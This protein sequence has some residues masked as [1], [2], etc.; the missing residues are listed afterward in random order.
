MPATIKKEVGE[1]LKS[2]ERALFGSKK[3]SKKWWFYLN[4][5]LH[6][7]NL[8]YIF[9]HANVTP[10]LVDNFKKT[11]QEIGLGNITWIIL[12]LVHTI[13]EMAK[14]NQRSTSEIEEIKAYD[15]FQRDIPYRLPEPEKSDEVTSY[16]RFNRV[17]DLKEPDRVPITPLMDYFYAANNNLSAYDFV[18][19]P[20]KYVFAAVR[21]TYQRFNGELDMVHVPMGRLYTFYNWLPL[22]TSGFYGD[23]HYP[24]KSP[25]SLQFLEKG[26]IDIEDFEKIKKL[27][28][29]SIWKPVNI[30][31]MRETVV[32]LVNIG[33]YID[34]WEKKEHV[35]IYA[36]SG[37]VT[38]LEG[39][40]YLMGIKKWL[41]AI[42]K[43]KEEMK[44]MCDF[45]LE[46]IMANNYMM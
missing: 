22:A 25:S 31:K 44:Q 12:Q 21:N 34:Y 8:L 17:V 1:R 20:F 29:R 43:N 16:Q 41:K 28:L 6:V 10:P 13:D 19:T 40:C 9:Q 27:G 39:L 5:R 15:P 38:P 24:D 3:V 42:L 4:F 26:Y 2:L 14:I 36:T 23:L 45:L 37:I 11:V 46:P 33:K 7:R 35:P 30:K 32:D 18:M